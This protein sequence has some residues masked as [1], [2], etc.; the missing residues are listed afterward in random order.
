MFRLSTGNLSE[1]CS[2]AGPEH[3][4][5]ERGEFT[6]GQLIAQLENFRG[7]EAAQRDEA[8]PHLLLTGLGGRFLVRA[9]RG[10]L[11]LYNA[12]VTVEPYAELTAQERRTFA[13]TLER[14]PKLKSDSPAADDCAPRRSE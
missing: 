4:T 9:G 6:G 8:D 11:F 2:Q 10:K 5:I 7:L 3:G 1:D 14:S 12:R 13:E